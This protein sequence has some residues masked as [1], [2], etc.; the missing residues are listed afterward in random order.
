MAGARYYWE[1]NPSQGWCEVFDRSLPGDKPICICRDHTAAERMVKALSGK[2]PGPARVRI[3][4]RFRQ[5]ARR[6]GVWRFASPDFRM[7]F[8]A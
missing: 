7:L 1:S 4:T 5:F 6:A 3:A 2:A 8:G